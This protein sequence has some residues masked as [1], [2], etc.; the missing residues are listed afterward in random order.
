[1]VV[2]QNNILK[3]L[4]YKIKGYI[5]YDMHP[6]IWILSGECGTLDCE[7]SLNA[8]HLEG[9]SDSSSSL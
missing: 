5:S 2:F 6:I 8:K 9:L 4:S 3:L 7:D 1:M